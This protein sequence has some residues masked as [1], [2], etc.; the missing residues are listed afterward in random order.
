MYPSKGVKDEYWLLCG[1]DAK[2][3]SSSE[4]G[5]DDAAA[6]EEEGSFE[7]TPLARIYE[8]SENT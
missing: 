4:S 5:S 2:E 1:V 8:I 3:D 7:T 6:E